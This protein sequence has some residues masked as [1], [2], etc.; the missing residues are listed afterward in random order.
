MR[1]EYNTVRF[2]LIGDTQIGSLYQRLDALEK[3]YAH[4]ADEGVE[5]ILHAGDDYITGSCLTWNK[6]Y[7]EERGKPASA[8]EFIKVRF[9]GCTNGRKDNRQQIYSVIM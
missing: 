6:S 2:G 8:V 3:F 7:A 5:T 9:V 4:C 1:S